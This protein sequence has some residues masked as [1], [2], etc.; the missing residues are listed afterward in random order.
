MRVL[1]VNE[2]DTRFYCSYADDCWVI[3]AK[4]IMKHYS[5][6]YIFLMPISARSQAEYDKLDSREFAPARKS[7]LKHIKNGPIRNAVNI[8][9]TYDALESLRK[10]NKI[11]MGIKWRDNYVEDFTKL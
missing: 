9:S 2:K 10:E 4:A 1:G 8:T 5:N 3:L 11:K 6:T 7:I